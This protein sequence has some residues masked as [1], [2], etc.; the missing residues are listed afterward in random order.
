M[1]KLKIPL[2]ILLTIVLLIAGASLPT[3]VAAVQDRVTVD[4][5]GFGDMPSIELTLSR[6]KDSMDAAEKLL[7]LAADNRIYISEAEA[8]M[9]ADDALTALC[10]EMDRYIDAGIFEWFDASSISCEPFICIDTNDTQRYNI[11]WTITMINKNE[12]YQVLMADM[13]DET[14]VIYSLRYEAYQEYALN[15]VWERN[16]TVMDAFTDLY[17]QALGWTEAAEYARSTGIG[18]EYLELD[19]EVSCARYSFGDTQY[20]EINMEFY[21]Y[22]SGGFITY[23]S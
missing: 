15:G 5:S 6:D 8:N 9:T 23:F 17:F 18:Y 4:H 12:P 3:I 19:G 7:L 22:G 20:G 11:F 2:L 1:R 14:G 16:E 13:D 10:A 21:V